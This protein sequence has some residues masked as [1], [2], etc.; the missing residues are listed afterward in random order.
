MERQ[1]FYNKRISLSNC[2]ELIFVSLSLS[3]NALLNFLRRNVMV[4]FDLPIRFAI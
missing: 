1:F 4:D 2:F 3:K